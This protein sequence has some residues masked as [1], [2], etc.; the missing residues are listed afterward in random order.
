[1]SQLRAVEHG[2]DDPAGVDHAASRAVIGPDGVVRQRSGALFTPD[3]L[4]ATVPLR[5]SQ[6]LATRAGAGP[7]VRTLGPGPGCGGSFG[8]VGPGQ[9]NDHRQAHPTTRCRCGRASRRRREWRIARDRADR[10]TPVV[11][12]IIPTYNERDNVEAIVGRLLHHVA[13]RARADRRRR[14]PGRH[15]QDRRGNRAPRTRGSTCCTARGRRVS[16]RRT[17]PASAGDS[18]DGLRRAGRD[19]CRRVARARAAAPISLAAL[20]RRRPRTRL[21]LGARRARRQ[22]AEV[23]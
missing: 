7:R 16:A 22:L 15:R 6:T 2:R 10:Q 12:V 4:V 5:T 1:M 11:L 17:S 20:D 8:A 21:A 9:Q 3:I 23:A 13:R 19:G 14:Q 18:S